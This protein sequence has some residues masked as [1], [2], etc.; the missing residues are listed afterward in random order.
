M[1]F[2]GYFQNNIGPEQYNGFNQQQQ[3]KKCLFVG[4]L[5]KGV[6]IIINIFTY[7]G[8]FLDHPWPTINLI[9]C[10]KFR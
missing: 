10:N 6:W 5:S 7:K 3:T 2:Y 8:I 1:I 4:T 9:F